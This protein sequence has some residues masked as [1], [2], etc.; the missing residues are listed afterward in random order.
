MQG[1][2]AAPLARSLSAGELMPPPQADLQRQDEQAGI[3][4][5]VNYGQEDTMGC[6]YRQQYRPTEATRRG[7]NLTTG[8]GDTYGS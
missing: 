5:L 6:G 8:L 2:R 4:T 7:G 3:R 1:R